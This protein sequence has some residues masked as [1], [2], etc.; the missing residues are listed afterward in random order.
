MVRNGYEFLAEHN[1]RDDLPGQ[2]GVIALDRIPE[3]LDLNC[4]EDAPGFIARAADW[5]K[6]DQQ[7]HSLAQVLLGRTI[8]VD[9]MERALALAPKCPGRVHLHHARR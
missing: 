2:V 6:C 8:I 9:V 4:Y 3:R 7:Y 1:R 5:V